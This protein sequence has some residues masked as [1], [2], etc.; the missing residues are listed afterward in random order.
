MDQIYQSKWEEQMNYLVMK[1]S[2]VP[3]GKRTMDQT[4][5]FEWVKYLKSLVRHERVRKWEE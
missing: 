1:W 3:N 2:N 4:Y 5:L